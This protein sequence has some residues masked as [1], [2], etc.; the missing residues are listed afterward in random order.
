[1]NSTNLSE[2]QDVL[3]F[4]F[5]ISD[6]LQ[7]AAADGSFDLKDVPKFLPLYG[8]AKAAI[9]GI[10][11]PVARFKNLTPGERAEL[12]EF[13]KERFDIPNDELESLIEDTLD[14]VVNILSISARW[15]HLRKAA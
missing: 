6:A 9:E 13:A 3:A 1:M 11:N 12:V 5:D 14:A 15:A 2:L 8:S 7:A 10:G 4:G